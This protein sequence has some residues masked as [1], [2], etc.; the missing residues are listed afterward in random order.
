M[1]D[2]KSRSQQRDCVEERGLRPLQAIFFLGI[3]LLTACGSGGEQPTI[4]P[5][6]A[7]STEHVA[8]DPATAVSTTPTD[9]PDPSPSPTLPPNFSFSDVTFYYDEALLGRATAAKIPAQLAALDGSPMYLPGVPDFIQITFAHPQA[10]GRPA[11]MLIQPMRTPAGEIYSETPEWHRQQLLRLEELLAAGV[12]EPLAGGDAQV[13]LQAFQSGTGMRRLTDSPDEFTAVASDGG[14]LYYTFDGVT[15]DGIYLIQLVY[16]V[17]LTD[18]MTGKRPDSREQRARLLENDGSGRFN[19]ALDALDQ[20]IASLVVGPNASTA[21]TLPTNPPGCVNDAVFVDDVT[22][23]D[24][25]LVEAGET[26]TKTWRLRNT[27]TCIWT[28]DYGLRFVEGDAFEQLAATIADITPPDSESDVSVT[29]RAPADPATYKGTWQLSTPDAATFGTTFYI[30]FEVPSPPNTLDGY[31]RVEGSI[32]YPAGGLPQMTIYFQRTDGSERYAL[33]TQE[34]WNRYVNEIPAG[35]YF[36]FAHVNGDTSD[37]GGGY[38]QFV[39]CGQSASCTDHALV[40]VVVREHRMTR[41]IDIAD[42]YAPA[43]SFPIPD[44][45]PG[46]TPPPATPPPDATEEPIEP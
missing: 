30:S 41:N 32:S 31:G 3:M 1:T 4:G 33:E 6:T 18:S 39:L 38:T 34:G 24:G 13:Q 12:A 11:T 35:E 43:G 44:E 20:M 10:G 5:A 2:M 27:G 7:E 19:P 16:A 28:A 36:V 29:L 17:E 42:W 8:A 26:V 9:P 37:S 15:H 14:E 22:I 23:P 25:T 45:P 46:E 40:P 21:A